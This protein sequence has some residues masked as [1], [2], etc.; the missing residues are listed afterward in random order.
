[1]KLMQ[2]RRNFLDRVD[3]VH[4]L[5]QVGEH[6]RA[7]LMLRDTGAE[8]DRLHGDMTRAERMGGGLSAYERARILHGIKA[9]HVAAR[10]H[11]NTLQRK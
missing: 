8:I 3:F 7:S 4:R 11:A 2:K 1:M 10:R 5:Q 9:L 6:Q